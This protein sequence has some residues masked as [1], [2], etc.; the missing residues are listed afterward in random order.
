MKQIYR[1]DYVLS[2]FVHYSTVTADVAQYFADHPASKP[3]KSKVPYVR[4][5][6]RKDWVAPETFLDE[7]TQ[8]TLIHT[9]SVLAHETMRRSHECYLNSTYNCIL[10]FAC[11]A[12][13]EFVDGLYQKNGF[14]DDAGNYCNCWPNDRIESVLIPR[15]EAILDKSMSPK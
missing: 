9:R 6:H 8:G 5:V 1:P 11:P 10:G 4:N 12:S 2:H 13:V 14:H 3:G 15:L 7:L